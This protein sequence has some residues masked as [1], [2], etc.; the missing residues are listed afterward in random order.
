MRDFE[1]IVEAARAE[2]A[3]VPRKACDGCGDVVVPEA[4]RSPLCVVCE[5]RRD[6]ERER[7]ALAVAHLEPL[8]LREGVAQRVYRGDLQ[9][10]RALQ[11]ARRWAESMEP[12]ILVLCGDPGT[13]KTVAA[14]WA[15]LNVTIRNVAGCRYCTA[16]VHAPELAR[17]MDPWGDEAAN[18]ERLD[19]RYRG[20]IVLDDLG[21]EMPTDRWQEQFQRFINARQAFGRTVIT[22]NLNKADIRPRYGD[23]VAD[24]LNDTAAAVELT[25]QSLRSP[26]GGF[27]S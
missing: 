14:A 25:G 11:A 7:E 15:A 6:D 27:K 10:T 3:K 26:R 20:L 13:G 1:A 18:V 16:I 5:R 2:W 24:R 9:D 19:P 8:E 22:T 12:P 17:R 23:R 4:S 21:C